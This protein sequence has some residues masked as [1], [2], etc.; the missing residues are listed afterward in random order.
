MF[1]SYLS[2]C[3]PSCDHHTGNERNQRMNFGFSGL[4][5]PNIPLRCDRGYS[6]GA[7]YSSTAATDGH[8]GSTTAVTRY[9]PTVGDW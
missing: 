6:E 1:L 3:F 8:R 9:S 7:V 4:S 5:G 2:R